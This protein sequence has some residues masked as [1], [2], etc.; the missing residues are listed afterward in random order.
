MQTDL[1]NQQE[2]RQNIP[3][4]VRELVLLE[5]LVRWVDDQAVQRLAEVQCALEHHR[6]AIPSCWNGPY[7]LPWLDILLDALLC[8]LS[9]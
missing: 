2:L 8:E 3:F 9:M 1:K 7:D 4:F 5:I 6:D